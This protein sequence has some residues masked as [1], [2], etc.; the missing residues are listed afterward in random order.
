MSNISYIASKFREFHKL[1]DNITV[2][3]IVNSTPDGLYDLLN[4]IT[5]EP[6]DMIAAIKRRINLVAIT[7]PFSAIQCDV[8]HEETDIERQIDYDNFLSEFLDKEFT[9]PSLQ[10]FA[11]CEKDELL[12]RQKNSDWRLANAKAKLAITDKEQLIKLELESL[13]SQLSFY[14]NELK[15]LTN[16]VTFQLQLIVDFRKELFAFSRSKSEIIRNNSDDLELTRD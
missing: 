8:I 16:I 7:E 1:P 15:R 11:Y 13:H 14:E 3:N 9:I 4:Q 2:Q 6:N 5:K 10:A 12:E